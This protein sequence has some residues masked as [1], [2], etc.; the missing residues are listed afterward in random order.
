M[1]QFSP[2]SLARL[3]QNVDR[4][5]LVAAVDLADMWDLFGSF[6]RAALIEL[7]ETQ[8]QE[9]NIETFDL[10]PSNPPDWNVE[11]LVELAALAMPFLPPRFRAAVG[12]LIGLYYTLESTNILIKG[13]KLV[14][15]ETETLR[16]DAREL[17]DIAEKFEDA[18]I[19]LG[20]IRLSVEDSRK[21]LALLDRL[22]PLVARIRAFAE[23]PITI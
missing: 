6:E 13:I 5:V 16:L 3:L 10:D 22:W 23:F 21:R 1:P 14:I 15:P 19:D 17:F 2:Q 7:G 9:A 8:N 12:V 20:G 11:S 18:L 4:K